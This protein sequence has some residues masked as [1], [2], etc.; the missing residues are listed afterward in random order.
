MDAYSEFLEMLN[1]RPDFNDRFNM[2]IELFGSQTKIV[3]ITKISPST[4]SAIKQRKNTNPSL[5]IIQKIIAG[6]S[7]R[8]SWLIEGDCPAFLSIN[9]NYNEYVE[10]AKENGHFIHMF[11]NEA[12]KNVHVTTS[13]QIQNSDVT[14]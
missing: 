10:W 12:L 2:L 6:T 14:T 9:S 11:R 7:C 3:E 4:V 8:I 13:S 5:K 1:E